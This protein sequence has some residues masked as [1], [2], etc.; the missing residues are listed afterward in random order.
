[1]RLTDGGVYA[2]GLGLIFWRLRMDRFHEV[3]D[4]AV[5]IVARSVYKQA[6]VYR[7]GAALYAAASGGFVRLYSGGGT[8]V[9]TIRWDDMEIPGITDSG[10]LKNDPH[11]KLSLP[12]TFKQ[13]EAKAN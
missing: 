6:K 4:A 2:H 9:P 12:A 1:M 8:G 11:G 7:R 13:I 3:A 10:A 5:I